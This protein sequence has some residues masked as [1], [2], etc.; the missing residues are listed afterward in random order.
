MTRQE[1]VNFLLKEKSG[2]F[3]NA[4]AFAPSNIALC[5]Y[6][7]KRDVE[8]NL[9]V[10]SSLSV[11]LGNLGSKTEIDRADDCDTF[12][13][14]NHPVEKE[15]AF[16]NRMKN[17]L[18]LFRPK[19]DFYFKVIT[20][21]NIPTAAGL[22]SSASG[23]AALTLALDKFFN[24]NLDKKTL[25]Q[26]ARLGS[27]S[28]SRSIYEGFVEWHAGKDPNGMDCYA[29]QISEQWNELCIGIVTVSSEAKGQSSGQAMQHTV[30]T[31]LLYKSWPE[32]SSTD[33][34]TLKKAIATKDFELFGQT[35]ETNAFS[36]H[37]TML[38]AWPP[39]FFWKPETL[40]IIENVWELRKQQH[41]LYITIDAGPN[42]KL[43]FLK[44][45]TNLIKEHFS[46]IKIIEPFYKIN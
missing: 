32:K 11:S 17:F 8:L 10:N 45:D 25:S 1:Y 30:S 24:W 13:H 44:K 9:P 3:H 35:A 18:S 16:Y 28:A 2:Q 36:M 14:N 39:V 12:I 38:S 34:A 40:T 31:S 26:L 20:E 6:W 29:E 15:S 23:F 46:S 43:L 7:G 5:K 27:G 41:H 42:V 37:A 4:K 22:A 21:N 33:L 19:S